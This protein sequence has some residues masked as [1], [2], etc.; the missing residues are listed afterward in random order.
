MATATA[1]T[2]TTAV[3]MNEGVP[4]PTRPLTVHGTGCSSVSGEVRNET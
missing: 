3:A 2:M 4:E 1:A